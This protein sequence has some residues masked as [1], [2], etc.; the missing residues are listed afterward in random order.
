MEEEE[1]ATVQRQQ[2]TASAGGVVSGDVI[3]SDSAGE[4]LDGQ[5]RGFM[6][7]R[8]NTD[9]SDVRVHTGTSAG[10]SADALAA[11]AYTTGR[12]IY[13][14][15][16]KYAPS[17]PAG[18][19]LLAHELTH[20]VQQASAPVAGAVQSHSVLVGSADSPL[21]ME[22]ERTADEV[23][24]SP[25]KPAS[26]SSDSTAPVRRGWTDYA[27]SAWNAT[28]GRVV[29]YVG[30]K[31]ED[32]VEGT[33]EWFLSKIEHYAPGLLKLLQGG[34]V[35]YLKDQITAGLDGIFGGLVSRIQKDGFLGAAAGVIGELVGSLN[36][37]ASGMVAGACESFAHAAEAVAS[38][39]KSIAGPALDGIKKVA[40]AVG[41]FFS[42]LWNEIGAPVWDA[43]KSVAG[44]VWDWI[45]STAKWIWDKTEP[46]RST[47][48]TAWNW[49]KKQF[50][51][52]WD[53]GAGVL[54]WLK[55]KA[56]AAWD[57]IYEFTKPIHGP[58]KVIGAGLLLLSPVGPVIL[59]WKGAP[60]LWDALT[61]LY[62]QW[63]KTDFIVLARD[64]LTQHILPAIAS[65]AQMAASLLEEAANWISEKVD[66]V[67]TALGGLLNALGA[68]VILKL[69]KNAVQ[70]VADEFRKFANWVKKDFFKTLHKAK[71]ILLKIW[72]FIK[73]IL[74]FLLK[75]AIVVAN[76]VLLPIVLTG[77]LWQALPACFKP[78]IIDFVLDLLIAL[79]RAL[80]TFKIFGESWPPT[81]AKILG[82]LT[83]VRNSSVEKKIEASNRVARI[84]S[85]DDLEWLGNLL[86]AMI[87]VPDHIEGQFEEELMGMDLTEPLPFE[88]AAE[89]TAAGSAAQGVASGTMQPEDAAVLSNPSLSPGQIGVDHVAEM[90]LEP[91][92][93][94]DLQAQ[95]GEKV[96]RGPEDPSRTIGGIQAEL[97][98]TPP[99]GTT[100]AP[101]EP[102]TASPG[103]AAPAALSTDEQL[104][105]FM[106]QPAPDTCTKEQPAK[107]EGGA[108]VP[109]ALKIG[110]LTRG[111]RARY[112]LHQIGQGIKTWFKCNSHWLIPAIIGV[113]AV[114]VGLQILTGGAITAAL[115][116]ILDIFAAIMIGVAAVRAAAYTAEYVTKAISG[117]V[118][119]AAKSLARGLAIVGIE[120]I[121]ALLFN[122]NKVID[123]LKK[124][125]KATAEAAANAAKTAVK[126][127]V[128]SVQKL[129]RIGAEGV[130]EAGKNI[131]G[132][133]RA[134]VKNG[135]LLLEGVTEGFGKGIRKVGE[136]FERLWKK[137]RFKAF[138]IR[139]EAGWFELDAEIN[140][141]VLLARGKVKWI[142]EDALDAAAR[143][144]TV[145]SKIKVGGKAALVIGK[146]PEASALVKL[147][148][149]PPAEGFVKEV[150]ELYEDSLRALGAGEKAGKGKLLQQAAIDALKGRS[151]TAVENILEGF[152]RA[153]IPE[154]H[155]DELLHNLMNDSRS[156]LAPEQMLKHL[157]EIVRMKPSGLAKLI[158]DLAVLGRNKFVGAEWVVR[159]AT[160]SPLARVSVVKGFEQ[161]AE[162]GG[163]FYDLVMGGVKYELK[164]W[165]QFSDV[166]R[167][168]VL[169]EL[170]FDFKSG[171]L[172]N[173]IKWV[174]APRIRGDVVKAMQAALNDAKVLKEV[175]M[176]T[177]QARSIEAMLEQF[178][179]VGF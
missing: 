137:L 170:L 16:G 95:G 45:E 92:L 6:E 14:A 146:T 74:A 149:H 179:S 63:K 26:I 40:S 75:L 27:K 97:A 69:A 60:Y 56:K 103:A 141:W 168:R 42:T 98:G 49:I 177:A 36:K 34:V 44:A 134:I 131:V 61:W 76:P 32:A 3:P 8:F 105:M 79:V 52:A 70:F 118:I 67:N 84:M 22:A 94:A 7:S 99:A 48:A 111:Q 115:P 160:E 102:G 158:D 24:S 129:G 18:Q 147:L 151:E 163:R 15:A 125:I 19:H 58:L 31:V 157:D 135:K 68:S 65:G 108:P 116:E 55:D 167:K 165:E 104:E 17:S 169:E 37:A 142:E 143:R 175:G 117:D 1:S 166:F 153:S 77:Y 161:L 23:M 156:V 85:G 89:P 46:I 72:S 109:E 62:E 39:A 4:P 47:V 51:I 132:F 43:I 150:K 54:D 107:K 136:L 154:S 28:G 50:G 152:R 59:I 122:L 174:F 57:K 148:Q 155:L 53:S 112:L 138:R 126:G 41:G 25:A 144:A 173:D 100:A 90:E 96:F 12:D 33:K 9:F 86:S 171:G 162:G 71:E 88:R 29:N 128:E 159:F 13:F 80:P 83:T 127:T 82:A 78:P 64:A 38:F 73:P 119:G 114:L 120:L 172:P 133:G 5:T 87:K 110:P 101:K 81:K 178:I 35:D 123:T 2:S 113:I 93:I 140:P 30:E 10:R 145:G 130:A 139:L 91:E 121:F 11:D 21:E 106:N 176:K 164:N 66:S 20:T 124:G